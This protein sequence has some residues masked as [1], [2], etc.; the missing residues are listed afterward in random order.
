M[1]S[2]SSDDPDDV[3]L[4]E[5]DQEELRDTLTGLA[6]TAQDPDEDE[7]YTP[8]QDEERSWQTFEQNPLRSMYGLADDNNNSSSNNN[9]TN[10]YIHPEKFVRQVAQKYKYNPHRRTE[11]N[12]KL[13]T[14]LTT[15]PFAAQTAKFPTRTDYKYSQHTNLKSNTAHTD[16]LY[17]SLNELEDHFQSY[18][19]RCVENLLQSEHLRN[20]RQQQAE[21]T[22]MIGNFLRVAPQ[23]INLSGLISDAFP[24]EDRILHLCVVNRGT[25]PRLARPSQATKISKP[26]RFAYPSRSRPRGVYRP[27]WLIW[28][29]PRHLVI[30][31]WQ[32]WG[33]CPP[34][35]LHKSLHPSLYL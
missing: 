31:I 17:D 8:T 23:R 10:G 14:H 28:H 32:I 21:I 30:E 19:L 22:S 2:Q 1:T 9:S 7:A 3:T 6:P 13:L 4:G 18:I 15:S 25:R 33:W 29:R 20:F 27:L 35:S 5:E 34:P 12:L 24:D 11:Q 26:N 16:A